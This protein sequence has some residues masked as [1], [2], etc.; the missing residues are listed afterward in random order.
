MEF[1]SGIAV[2]L[3]GFFLGIL[4]SR[5]FLTNKEKDNTLAQQLD[6]VHADYANYQQKVD[7]HFTVTAE[8]VNKLT[9]AYSDIH[10][11]LATGAHDLSKR[12]LAQTEITQLQVS[13]TKDS[14]APLMASQVIPK[15]YAPKL[16]NESGHLD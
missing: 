7:E 5:Q 10:S 14:K 15:D 13:Q 2:L 8:L 6:D 11:H 4:F 1:L 3:I 12:A 9:Y 16:P